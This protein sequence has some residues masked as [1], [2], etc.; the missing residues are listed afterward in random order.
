[1]EGT[2]NV[3]IHPEVKGYLDKIYVEEGAFVTK[4]QPLFAINSRPFDEQLNNAQANLLA[5]KANLA[6][7]QI[8]VNKVEPLLKNNVVSDVQLKTAQASYEDT[9]SSVGHAVV[10]VSNAK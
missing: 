5:A 8:N 2:Q 4:G 6:N 3:N 9:K 7:A 1:M 10:V